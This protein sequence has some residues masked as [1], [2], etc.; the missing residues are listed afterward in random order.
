MVAIGYRHLTRRKTNA[1]RCLNLFCAGDLDDKRTCAGR[2]ICA[3]VVVRFHSQTSG[4]DVVER[5][6]Q[7]GKRIICAQRVWRAP[8]LWWLIGVCCFAHSVVVSLVAMQRSRRPLLFD[9]NRRCRF[10]KRIAGLCPSLPRASPNLQSRSCL[11]RPYHGRPLA[12]CLRP[13]H[14]LAPPARPLAWPV[15]RRCGRHHRRSRAAQLFWVAFLALL[16]IFA[17]SH[18]RRGRA[19]D[20]VRPFDVGE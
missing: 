11:L 19:F 18:S 9:V 17:E 3:V 12:A 1:V 15:V 14:P 13:S 2:A 16:R 6:A 7:D 10:L 20:D 8:P 4:A 5:C